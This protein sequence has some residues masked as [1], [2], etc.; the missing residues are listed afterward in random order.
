MT[1]AHHPH[2]NESAHESLIKTPKQLIL[3]VFFAFAVPI[4]CIGLLA[5][6]VSSEIRPSAGSN[7][8]QPE[9]IVARISPV[10]QVEVNAKAAEAPPA[11]AS[12]ATPAGGAEA[13]AAASAKAALANVAAAAATPAKAEAG[14]PPALYTQACF[15]CHGTGA[16]GA[17][18]LG[19]KAAW[20]ERLKLG[21]DG[22]TAAAIKGIGAMPPR[23]G[24]TASDADIKDVVTYMVHAVE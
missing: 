23:G 15:A 20:A 2:A 21:I 17:P 19:D 4:F 8:M 16:A 6:L 9:A 24:S 18:K 14:K 1:E 12:A 5:H 10:G 11:A 22:L 7:A 3:T 13:N